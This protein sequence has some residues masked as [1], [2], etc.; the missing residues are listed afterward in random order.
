MPRTLE[1]RG[2][3]S[4]GPAF[5]DECPYPIEAL[6]YLPFMDAD[7]VRLVFGDSERCCYEGPGL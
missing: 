2:T 5:P 1:G 4:G 7:E 3:S 6:P